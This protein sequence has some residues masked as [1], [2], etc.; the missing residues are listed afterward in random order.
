MQILIAL[1]LAA[2]SVARTSAREDIYKLSAG[3]RHKQPYFVDEEETRKTGPRVSQSAAQETII[4][5]LSEDYEHP[6]TAFIER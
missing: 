3:Y 5:A 6:V 1:L 4:S 2:T